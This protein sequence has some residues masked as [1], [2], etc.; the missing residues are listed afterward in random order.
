LTPCQTGNMTFM[1]L[2]NSTN[3]TYLSGNIVYDQD[4]L[5]VLVLGG[6]G[7]GCPGHLCNQDLLQVLI[8]GVVDTQILAS[9]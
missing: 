1:T 9:Y 2:G 8:L 6:E 5:H 7:P 4:L 3:K